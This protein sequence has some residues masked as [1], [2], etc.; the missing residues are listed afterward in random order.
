MPA[1]RPAVLCLIPLALLLASCGGDSTG[2][3]NRG[4]L[5][6]IENGDQ[7]TGTVGANL[8]A[9]LEVRVTD[10]LDHPVTGQVVNFIVLAG[11][12]DITRTAYTNGNGVASA[13]WELGTVAGSSQQVEARTLGSDG[14]RKTTT[15]S[16]T[17]RADQPDTISAV[18]AVQLSAAA[19][20]WVRTIPSVRLADRFG[21]LVPN[22][23]V[24]FAVIS[25]GGSVLGAVATSDSLGIASV[26]RWTLGSAQGSNQLSAMAA[27]LAPVLFSATATSPIASQVGLT[28]EPAPVGQSGITLTRQPVAQIMNDV[29]DPIP[30]AAVSVT[31]SL[32][33]GTGLLIGATAVNTDSLGIATF[34]NLAIGGTVGLFTVQFTAASL[35]PDTSATIALAAGPATTFGADAGLNLNANAGTALPIPPAVTVSDDWGNGIPGVAVTFT[36]LSG[37]GFITGS[38]QVTGSDGTAT[39]GSWTLGPLPGDNSLSAVAGISGLI[40]NP[41]TI[42]ATGLGDFWSPRANMTTPRRFAGYATYNGLLYTVGGKDI[43]LGTTS[44][45][46]VYN[47]AVN[48]WSPRASMSTARVGAAAGFIGGKLYVAGGTAS[49]NQAI[50]TGEVYASNNTWTPIAAMPAPRN[51]PAF[52]VLNG[53]LFLAGGGDDAGQL[54]TVIAYDP[55]GNT[56]NPRASLPALRNDAVGVVINGLFYLIGGQTGNTADGALLVYDPQGDSWTP[57]AS[58]PTARYHV[59]AE[60]LNG[61]IYV[62]SGLLSGGTTSPVVEVY[63]PATDTWSPS[64][65]ITTPRSAG[66]IAVINGLLY[67]AGGSSNNTVTG[68]VE[69]YVP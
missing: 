57:L 39:V 26:Q 37:G 12:G 44:V 29:G 27:G 13:T 21:N 63:D 58:M 66:A 9:P 14:I 20:T 61:K 17:T 31:A 45:T 5:I 18:S 51:F 60:V 56:W 40:G 52:A 46:E 33:S 67:V 30:S 15:F 32:V 65:D 25:G 23:Q 24:T 7:Q 35:A 10:L 59:N 53:E 4:V 19:G 54:G 49:N 43:N 11:G 6:K 41:D 42:N 38:N 55:V 50:A 1:R 62:V 69:A 36:V 8:P 68:V 3:T 48:A 64:A 28:V 2:V 16:A 47:P 22:H 34:S